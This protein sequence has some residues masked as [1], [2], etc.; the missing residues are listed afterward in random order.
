MSTDPTLNNQDPGEQGEGN[1][2]SLETSNYEVIRK[3]LVEQGRTLAKKA[4]TLN[5]RRQDFFGSTSMEVIGNQ[6]IT[7]ENNCIPQ[8]IINLGDTLLFGYNVHR[9]MSQTQV[10][11]VFSLHAFSKKGEDIVLQHIA[12]DTSANFLGE[13]AF[14]DAF[15]QLYFSFKDAFLRQLRRVDGR[16]L[17]IFQTGS[18]LRDIR[19]FRWAVDAQNNVHY[20]DNAGQKDNTHIPPHD[21]E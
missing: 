9:K 14:I 21:F 19:V 2:P 8:D 1:D 20:I 6:T 4:D 5:Q 3:R 17:A 11:D 12:Q 13:P 10:S 16:L 15:N 7:T 18:S